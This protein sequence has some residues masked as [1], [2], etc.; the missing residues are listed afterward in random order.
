MVEKIDLN[1]F[2]VIVAKQEGGQV[3][4]SI[5]QIKEVQRITFIELAKLPASAVMEVVERYK[6]S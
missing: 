2:A 4:L 1:D 6:N 3:N 5:A